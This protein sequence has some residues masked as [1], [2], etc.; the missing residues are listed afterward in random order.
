[1]PTYSVYVT[2]SI[3]DH[4]TVEA[5]NADEAMAI[6]ESDPQYEVISNGGYAAM[7]DSISAYDC[8]LED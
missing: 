2:Y 7:W 5:D 4:I 6:A 8:V 3:D 1:M